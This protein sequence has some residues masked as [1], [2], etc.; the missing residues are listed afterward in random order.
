MNIYAMPNDRLTA[1]KLC[2]ALTRPYR[3]RTT[4][5]LQAT[6]N[7]KKFVS[8][9]DPT[10]SILKPKRFVKHGKQE[11]KIT[12]IV[13]TTTT[14]RSENEQA[15]IR[16]EIFN[17]YFK[18][19]KKFYLMGEWRVPNMSNCKVWNEKHLLPDA[20]YLIPF[21][22]FHSLDAASSLFTVFF[23]F[24]ANKSIHHLAVYLS[25]KQTKLRE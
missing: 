16:G 17:K 13:T 11:E 8:T 5:V 3:A 15:N 21:C 23:E 2:R 24:V 10:R 7:L 18:K 19:K 6:S 14:V 25:L 20:I 22:L 9:F 4:A 12:T 1:S